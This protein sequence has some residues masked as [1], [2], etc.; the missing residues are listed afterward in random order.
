[1]AKV[2]FKSRS[3]VLVEFEYKKH[4]REAVNALIKAGIVF[5]VY[6]A[7]KRLEVHGADAAV[8]EPWMS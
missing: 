4:L 6:S 3:Q 8:L 2:V 5:K 1:M 7:T